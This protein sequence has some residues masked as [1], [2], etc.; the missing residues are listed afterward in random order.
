VAC[1]RLVAAGR[2]CTSRWLTTERCGSEGCRTFGTARRPRT[3]RLCL[4]AKPTRTHRYTSRYAP[5]LFALAVP[6]TTMLLAASSILATL[7]PYRVKVFSISLERAM[8]LEKIFK[9][10]KF[11]FSHFAPPINVVRRPHVLGRGQ[12]LCPALLEDYDPAECDLS[13]CKGAEELSSRSGGVLSGFTIVEPDSALAE[14]QAVDRAGAF[15]THERAHLIS[16]SIVGDPSLADELDD[17]FWTLAQER[18]DISLAEV[19]KLLK[20]YGDD[21]NTNDSNFVALTRRFHSAFD[22]LS[23][24]QVSIAG[25]KRRKIA[26]G[27]VAVLLIPSSV[28][29]GNLNAGAAKDRRCAVTASCALCPTLSCA[30]PLESSHFA[31]HGISQECCRRRDRISHGQCSRRVDRHDCVYG[32][33]TSGGARL[34]KRTAAGQEGVSSV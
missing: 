14:F 9:D 26:M 22:G 6:E 8:E 20:D 15:L 19:K 18:F 2:S 29:E 7:F 31:T 13:L 28:R 11:M 12:E 17:A 32:V 1:K 16:K 24:H 23:G 3:A 25:S 10:W 34:R 33:A 30:A 27:N 21:L 5:S 4:K